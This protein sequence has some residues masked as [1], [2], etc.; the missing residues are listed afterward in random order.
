MTSE[1]S[2]KEKKTMKNPITIDDLSVGDQLVFF[3]PDDKGRTRPT[4][5]TISTVDKVGV[6]Y[7][8]FDDG[9]IFSAC[10]KEAI[11]THLTR[12][13][14]TV[15]NTK[16][17]DFLYTETLSGGHIWQLDEPFANLITSEHLGFIYHKALLKETEKYLNRRKIRDGG[18]ALVLETDESIAKRNSII[19]EEVR[20]TSDGKM[21]TK[22]GRRALFEKG[23]KLG[24]SAAIKRS[25]SVI[26]SIAT[27]NFCHCCGT[28]LKK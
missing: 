8:F 7:C 13:P 22:A 19:E 27:L 18:D 11:P 14:C 24:Y 12:V 4:V 17:G 21:M 25:E 26:E 9:I 3:K 20:R 15:R 5:V 2:G 10:S 16:E 6:S 1:D 28:R 23:Y